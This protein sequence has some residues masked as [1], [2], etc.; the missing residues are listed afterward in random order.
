MAESGRYGHN[1]VN[2]YMWFMVR[3]FKWAVAEEMIPAGVYDALRA[4]EPLKAGEVPGLR[5]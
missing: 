4:L 5:E 3:A 1:V 2:R